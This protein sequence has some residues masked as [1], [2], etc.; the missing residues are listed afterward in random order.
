M[1][2]SE[3]NGVL[4]QRMRRMEGKISLAEQDLPEGTRE[5]TKRNGDL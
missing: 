3:K 1:W 4:E 2:L 5:Q